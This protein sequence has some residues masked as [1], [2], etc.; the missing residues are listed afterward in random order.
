MAKPCPEPVVAI[1]R[2]PA[3]RLRFRDQGN[4][5]DVQRERRQKVLDRIRVELPGV[6]RWT[7]QAKTARG[8]RYPQFMLHLPGGRR[9]LINARHLVF[10]LANGWVHGEVQ[11]YR[12]RDRDP[13][14]VNPD[15]LKP[16]PV[17]ERKRRVSRIMSTAELREHFG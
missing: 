6:W 3:L 5:S 4:L 15:N 8:M 9:Q 11:Q 13:L 16:V 17:L 14:N 7:G 12:A 10:Y 2:L 1:E